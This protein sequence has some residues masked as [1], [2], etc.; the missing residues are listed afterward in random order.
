MAGLIGTEE[1]RYDLNTSVGS[2][3]VQNRLEE[4]LKV[5]KG[6]TLL[7]LKNTVLQKEL[8]QTNS[9]IYELEQFVTDLNML[10]KNTKSPPQQF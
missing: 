1:N 6:D 3:V 4:G 7:V 9:R 2:F 10:I 5:K 8:T